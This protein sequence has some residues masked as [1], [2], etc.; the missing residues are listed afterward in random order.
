MSTTRNAQLGIMVLLLVILLFHTQADARTLEWHA[1][2]CSSTPS[3]SKD[4]CVPI[5]P[6]QLRFARKILESVLLNKYLPVSASTID[7]H[8]SHSFAI[9]TFIGS[10]GP[11]FAGFGAEEDEWINVLKYFQASMRASR[12]EIVPLRKVCRRPETDYRLKML[13]ASRAGSLDPSTVSSDP[14]LPGSSKEK[15]LVAQKPPKQRKLMDVNT[16][17]VTTVLVRQPD[18]PVASETTPP[19]TIA[20]NDVAAPK[21]LQVDVLAV[22]SP[23]KFQDGSPS[24]GLETGSFPC[25]FIDSGP[26]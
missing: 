23:D 3:N 5:S 24:N 16:A 20:E 8:A 4:S 10:S 21:I 19:T 15:S 12:I 6:M 1:I 14:I 25:H 2:A 9:C 26:V 22:V 18:E 13:H 11:G 7:I 17:E